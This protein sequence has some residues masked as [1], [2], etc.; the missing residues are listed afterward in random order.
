MKNKFF[1]AVFLL[2]L[3]SQLPTFADQKQSTPIGPGVTHHHEFRAS[4]PWHLNVIEIDLTNQWIQLQ[5]VKARD[6][7]VGLEKTSAMAARNDHESHRVVGAINA[8]F[9]SSDGTPVGAQVSNGVLLKGPIARSVFGV[10]DLKLPLIDIVYL[11]GAISINDSIS[12]AINGVNRT[13]GTNELIIYNKFTGTST[14]TNYWGTEIIGEY[15]TE[16]LAVNDTFRIRVTAKDSIQTSGHGNNIIPD[17]GIVISG[18]GNSGDFLNQNLFVGD[19]IAVLVQLPPVQQRLLELVGGTPRIIR[20]GQVSVEYTQEGVGRAFAY[21]RHPRTAVGFSAD[22][23]RVYFFTVDGRQPG[24]SVGMSLFE[25]ANYM[26]EWDVS[27]AVNLDG[28]GST[29]MVVRGNIVNSPSDAAGERSVSNALLCISAA[30]TSELSILRLSPDEVFVLSQNDIQFTV[31][32]FDQYYNP[33]SVNT[34]SL[35]WDCD[36]RIGTISNSGLFTAGAE[37]DSGYV[38]CAQGEARDSALVHVTRVASIQLFPNPLILKVGD[39]LSLDFLVQDSFGNPVQ[40]EKNALSWTVDGDFGT[41]SRYGFFRAVKPG[42]G[43]IIASYDAVAGSSAVFVGVAT[44]WII[45]DFTS[46]SAWN[47]SGLRV[48]LSASRFSASSDRFISAP[49][50]GKLEYQ[51]TTGGTSALYLDCSHQ[52]SGT[53]EAIGIFVYGD[54]KGHWLRG[55]FEDADNEKF[56]V[57]FTDADSG[58][59]WSDAWRYL[60]IKFDDALPHWGNPAAELNFPITWKRIYL[61]ETDESK[62]DA[63]VIYLD[64][65]TAHFIETNVP[66]DRDQQVPD[67]YRLEQNF[68][69]PFNA[70]T[71]IAFSLPQSRKIKLDV[72]NTVGKLVHTLVDA[73]LPAGRHAAQFDGNE[74]ASGIYIYRINAGEFM[75]SKK[76]LLIK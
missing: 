18:H 16:Q 25:L 54:G 2:C 22:S 10:S 71:E 45:D 72:F 7:I 5:T 41:I 24:Y 65:F 51:L 32:G 73:E 67:S 64:D 48:D 60:R 40:M 29:T 49:T 28:G 20:D 75:F 74:L 59:Y 12:K 36:P 13:R 58:I 3:L 17:N 52:I 26:L 34:S 30:P 62:K 9:F 70:V 11:S 63:G 57:N 38:Y 8:D 66:A 15:I 35:I 42:Q 27:H 68:P 39:Y 47:L 23:T 53:P 56:L 21:D 31:S 55:E 14:G 50:S 44:D 43:H 69:N 76:M 33:V 1:I 19:T 37:E 46:T 6:L 4:G 61:A